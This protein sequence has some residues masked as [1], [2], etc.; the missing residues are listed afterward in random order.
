MPVVTTVSLS[1]SLVVGG[2][3][4]VVVLGSTGPVVSV[5]VVGW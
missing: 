1:L 5:V 4:L 2:S 3:P